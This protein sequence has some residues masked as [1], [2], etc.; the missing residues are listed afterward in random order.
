MSMAK[1]PGGFTLI[2]VLVALT[3]CAVALMAS[4]KAVSR[5][6]DTSVDLRL[7][8]LAQWSAENRLAV[9]R[10]QNE[11][12][13]TGSRQFDCPQAGVALVC[14]EEVAAMPEPSFRRVEVIVRGPDG[15]QLARLIAFPSR[16]P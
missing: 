10:I 5:M 6:A 2:E 15:N 9:I 3:I 8:T 7:R 11:L 1:R 16:L 13:N 14:T 12:P 4:L